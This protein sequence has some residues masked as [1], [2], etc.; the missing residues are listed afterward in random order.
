MAKRKTDVDDLVEEQ[1]QGDASVPP[2]SPEVRPLPSTSVTA[3]DEHPEIVCLVRSLSGPPKDHES[4]LGKMRIKGD[5]AVASAMFYR[6]M[7][8]LP[9][10]WPVS[11]E[12][13]K[14]GVTIETRVFQE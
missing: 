14:N 5:D 7:N 3:W 11:V 8:R 1:S 2:G 13:Q 4:S 9:V 6:R 10:T 12:V